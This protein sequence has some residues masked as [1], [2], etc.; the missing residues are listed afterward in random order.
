MEIP[1][2]RDEYSVGISEIDAQHKHLFGLAAALADSMRKAA[3]QTDL[4]AVLD[5]LVCYADEH[6]AF[7]E[8]IMEKIDY[9]HL[10]Y[11]QK[12]HEF[13]RTR[14]A[15]LKAQLNEGLLTED[16]LAEFMETW[17]TEHIIMEDMRYIAAVAAKEFDRGSS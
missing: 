2:W 1:E 15:L 14:I 13:M 4:N 9:E 3:G 6:F 8:I 7:E 16:E 10:M 5:E 11:H 12:M 17:L